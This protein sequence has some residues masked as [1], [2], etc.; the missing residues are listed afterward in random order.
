MMVECSYMNLCSMYLPSDLVRSRLHQKDQL[1]F[2][3]VPITRS[4]VNKINNTFNGLNQNILARLDFKEATST[5][6]Y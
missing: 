1:Q 5:S 3:I 4:R 2:L 6:E